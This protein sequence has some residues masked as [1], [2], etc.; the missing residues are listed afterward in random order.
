MDFKYILELERFY[1]QIQAPKDRVKASRYLGIYYRSIFDYQ[2][3]EKYFLSGMKQAKQIEDW[4]LYLELA[5]ELVTVYRNLGQYDKLKSE[6]DFCMTIVHQQGLKSKELIPLM[7]LALYYSYDTKNYEQGIVYGELFLEKVEYFKKVA[8]SDEMLAYRV[9]TEAFVIKIELAKCYIKTGRNFDLALKYLDE[10]KAFFEPFE[11][12]EKL[13]RIDQEY[14]NYYLNTGNLEAVEKYLREYNFHLGMK[15]KGIMNR[16]NEIPVYLKALSELEQGLE[17]A[18]LKNRELTF[19]RRVFIAFVLLILSL[20]AIYFYLTTRNRRIQTALNASLLAQNK[21]LEDVNRDKSKFFSVV[22][23]ELRTPIYAITGLTSV[24][25]IGNVAP[26][27]IKAIKHS[28]DY[29]L[30]LVNNILHMMS[31]EQGKKSPPQINRSHFDLTEILSGIVDSSVYF[32]DQH[33]VELKLKL[34]WEGELWVK[35]ERQKLTQILLNLIVNGIKYSG[36]HEVVIGA[37]RFITDAKTCKLMFEV[38]DQGVGISKEKQQRMFNFMDR[39]DNE[40]SSQNPFDLH[41]VGIG[42]FVVEKLLLEMSSKIVLESEE[43]KGS[44]FSF[45]LEMEMGE[46]MADE[47]PGLSPAS[48]DRN[49]L[50]VDDNEINLMVADRL[51]ASLGYK[52]FKATD[53]DDVVSIVLREKIDLVLM[54][55][56]MPAFSGYELARKIKEK[57]DIP[58]IAHTAVAEEE[59]D[60]EF[61]R[62][63]GIQAYIIK[64]Y[65]LDALRKMLNDIFH[66]P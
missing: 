59:L 29:L 32:A 53:T 57:M 12:Y 35:G 17:L 15:W 26:Q 54:D 34:N 63:S 38:S 66:R 37:K 7:E 45:E 9:K 16:T 33:H 14:L 47:T 44:V 23:H 56:N 55:L 58:I 42:L 19:E 60:M 61:L 24:M 31:F 6:I 22:S 13:A 36:D 21:L 48:F 18:Q 27:Q 43:G 39:I 11:D 65:P 41:G 51:V 10:A 1:D 2:E 8:P 25:D 64:P 49:I 28:G 3:S 5:K 46:D 50:V 40:E 62:A 52:C 4:G 30:L 20:A